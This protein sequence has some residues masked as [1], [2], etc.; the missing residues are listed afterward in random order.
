MNRRILAICIQ[1][2]LLLASAGGQQSGAPFAIIVNKVNRYDSLNRAKLGY[3]FLGKI[4]RWPWGAEV[5]PVDVRGNPPARAVFVKS[6]LKTTVED[7]NAYWIDQKMTRNADPPMRVADWA[8]VKHMVAA[9]PGA[10]GFIPAD[11][12]DGTVKVLAVE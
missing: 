11:M 9:K 10:V 6:I 7:L 1:G 8:A 12:V 5:V 2:G 3:I 4:S